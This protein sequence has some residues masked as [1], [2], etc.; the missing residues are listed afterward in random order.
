MKKSVARKIMLSV[1]TGTVLMSSNVVWAEEVSS[2]NSN[3]NKVVVDNDYINLY[4]DIFGGYT[5]TG[6]A[7]ENEV[8]VLGGTFAN[9]VYGGYAR[10]GTANENK[11][12][13]EDG[14]IKRSIYGGRST[15]SASNNLITINGGIT[16]S[17]IYGGNTN[18]GNADNNIVIIKE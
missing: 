15:D 2:A 18:S 12:T 4:G 10:F 16:K 14:T 17:F 8:I 6:T 7:N 13:I 9:G 3:G 5:E 1:L 11:I